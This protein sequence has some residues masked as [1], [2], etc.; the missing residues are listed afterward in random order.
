MTSAQLTLLMHGTDRV[1][2]VNHP[3]FH[4]ARYR[5]QFIAEARLDARAMDAYKEKKKQ[6]PSATF[7]L[8][9]ECK[10][11]LNYLTTEKKG[12]NMFKASIQ[13]LVPNAP[14]DM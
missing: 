8:H 5:H 1:F 7:T 13:I 10:E 2:L 12:H 3:R 6:N 4:L 14:S 11:D 9:S